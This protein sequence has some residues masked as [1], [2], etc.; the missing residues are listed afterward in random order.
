MEKL[1]Q[2]E[3]KA[4]KYHIDFDI[5][6]IEEGYGWKAFKKDIGLDKK[7]S[8]SALKKIEAMIKK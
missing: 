4:I 7:T 3:L 1:T 6:S 2:A 8:Y 5:Q